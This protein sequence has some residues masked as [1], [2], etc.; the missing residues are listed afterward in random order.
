V[1]V[2]KIFARHTVACRSSLIGAALAI[3]ALAS[4]GATSFAQTPAKSLK[5]QLVGHWQL[6]SVSVNNAK[7]YGANPQGSMFF[8]A[9]GHYSVIVITGGA[10]KSVSYFGTYIVNDAES[11][12]TMHID[13]SS[14][15]N[16]AG[17]DEARFVTFSGDELV[18]A[19]QK[20]AGP[21]GDVK[22]TWKRAN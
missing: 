1:R 9:G 18:V 10:A 8:D 5:D 14:L 6:V 20:S 4:I 22:L 2:V 19:N 7:P 11:S 15:A 3:A 21:V 16:A 17:R 12:M 13:A